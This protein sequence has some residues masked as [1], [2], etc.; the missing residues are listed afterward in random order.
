VL[1]LGC[2]AK[3]RVTHARARAAEPH[4]AMLG[5]LLTAACGPLQGTAGSAPEPSAVAAALQGHQLFVY[6]GHG[7]G[8]QYIGT[9]CCQSGP[10]LLVGRQAAMCAPTSFCTIRRSGA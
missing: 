3:L 6:L 5:L 7:G 9:P 4:R 10:V 1:A 8:E 2:R